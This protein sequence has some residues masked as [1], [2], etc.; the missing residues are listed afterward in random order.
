MVE[1]S[2][3]SQLIASLIKPE[4]ERERERDIRLDTRDARLLCLEYL[5]EIDSC[6]CRVVTYELRPAD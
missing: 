3:F 1:L 6:C 4:I 5:E 2:C